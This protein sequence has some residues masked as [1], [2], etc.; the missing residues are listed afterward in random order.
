MRKLVIA[1]L[2]FD[3]GTDIAFYGWLAL[4]AGGWL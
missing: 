2:V 3:V 1:W 4:K